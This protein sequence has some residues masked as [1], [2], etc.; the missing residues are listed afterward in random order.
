MVLSEPDIIVES[1]SSLLVL[2]KSWLNGQFSPPKKN[3]TG[4]DLWIDTPFWDNRKYL[5]KIPYK[6]VYYYYKG[7]WKASAANTLILALKAKAPHQRFFKEEAASMFA[8]HLSQGVEHNSCVIFVM[9]SALE[10]N[11][12]YDDRWEVVRSYLAKVRPDLKFIQAINPIEAA[13][14]AHNQVASSPDRDPKVIKTRL[15]WVGGLDLGENTITLVDDVVT[16]GGHFR[17]YH[18]LISEN[19]PNA[20]IIPMAWAAFATNRYDVENYAQLIPEMHQ[21][22]CERAKKNQE[23]EFFTHSYSYSTRSFVAFNLPQKTESGV[24][25]DIV[26]K[27]ILHRSIQPRPSQFIL[28]GL[29]EEVSANGS[30]SHE[31]VRMCRFDRIPRWE[32]KIKGGDTCNPALEFYNRLEGLSVVRNLIYPECPLS[33]IFDDI[34]S[35]FSGQAVDF[36]LPQAKLVIEIDG[37]QHREPIQMCKDVA[38]DALLEEAGISVK[39]VSVSDY[40]G[41]DALYQRLFEFEKGEVASAYRDGAFRLKTAHKE[42]LLSLISR[43][44]VIICEMVLRGKLKWEEKWEIHIICSDLYQGINSNRWASIAIEDLVH[45]RKALALLN[46]QELQHTTPSIYYYRNQ[47]DLPDRIDRNSTVIDISV[48]DRWDGHMSSRGD[49]I[50][51]RNH[52][53]ERVYTRSNNGWIDIPSDHYRHDAHPPVFW[54]LPNNKLDREKALRVILCY[55]Y[56]HKNFRVGQLEIIEHSMR[57]NKTAGLLATG[58]GKSLC[59][60]LSN[61]LQPGTCLVVSPIKSLMYDQCDELN[62]ASICRNSF[63]NGDVT[64]EDRSRRM[65]DLRKGRYHFV[66]VSPE[67]FQTRLFRSSIR[68]LYVENRMTGFVIDEAHCLSEWGHDFRV[69]YL[70][71]ASTLRNVA[72]RLKV[73]L[74][75]ATASSSVLHDIKIEFSLKDSQVIAPAPPNR[76]ELEFRV[77]KLSDKNARR[78]SIAVY[79]EKAREEVGGSGIVFCPFV[80]GVDGVQEIADSL[81]NHI[82]DKYQ[83]YQYS[84]SKPKNLV[85]RGSYNEHK[86]NQQKLFKKDDKG[87]MVA[88][89][90]FG[91]G[92]NKTDV[93]YT[94]H[95]G[96]PSSMEALYQEA[97]R[98]G[99]N[100]Q[101]S[102]CYV[103][104][105]EEPQKKVYDQVCSQQ[106]TIAMLKKAADLPKH[107]KGDYLSQLY[108]IASNET[109]IG[110]HAESITELALYV[111]HAMEGD[112]LNAGRINYRGGN[113]EKDIYRLRQLGVIE[114]WT[115]EDFFGQVYTLKVNKNIDLMTVLKST[116]DTI[117]KYNSEEADVYRKT[118]DGIVTPELRESCINNDVQSIFHKIVS[119]LLEWNFKQFVWTRRKSLQNLYE[120]CSHYDEKKKDQFK[121]ILEDAF[122]INDLSYLVRD[123]FKTPPA[124]LVWPYLCDD[125]PNILI[126]K[127][128]GLCVAEID[129]D[130]TRELL[131][132]L[133]RFEET[134]GPGA[135][136]SMV[137]TLCHGVLGNRVRAERNFADCIAQLEKRSL[138]NDSNL[139]HLAKFVQNCSD[140]IHAIVFDE[141]AQHPMSDSTLSYMTRL[142]PNHSIWFRYLSCKLQLFEK[143]SNTIKSKIL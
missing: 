1:V 143:T 4:S 26:L 106:A 6:F 63:I 19:C 82:D 9:P 85:V 128:K 107:K 135:F 60:Q 29:K 54:N 109:E 80:N 30:G 18:D 100:R 49:S 93:N 87:L 110:L 95:S 53:V 48:L 7:G 55:V 25:E 11:P 24:I 118:L 68:S 119:V 31:F 51:V 101:K 28:R 20:R 81:K 15:E 58:G 113:I 117:G 130:D 98:A 142:T 45:L 108:M 140:E 17:A 70:N 72:E 76:E 14:P 61:L 22:S 133:I 96:I 52:F 90:A 89:K 92:V 21:P 34:P 77:V 40:V 116:L 65:N 59:Y 115:V 56:G 62:H 124:I 139:C 23:I 94:I 44:Q 127:I 102:Y 13:E 129:E 78:E 132:Q 8:K 79:A 64:G 37:S 10:D 136:L 38:R 125:E 123:L 32:S 97:G 131:S 88:T 75:T 111:I 126:E 35:R 47:D 138:L 33:E 112:I 41:L 134:S 5:E 67:R 3:F 86:R 42:L 141:I 27:K 114:D 137:I 66:F 84:G 104:F 12:N 39:R 105:V 57:N 46:G 120:A 43:L 16:K 36:Y 83:V 71:L 103:L 99:R 50:I 122:T 73:M 2:L 121:K 91:M 74:L 69:S